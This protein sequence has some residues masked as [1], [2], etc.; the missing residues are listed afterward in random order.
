PDGRRA[1]APRC[2]RGPQYRTRVRRHEP[3]SHRGTRYLCHRALAPRRRCRHHRPLHPRDVEVRTAHR[4]H[5]G[6]ETRSRSVDCGGDVMSEHELAVPIEPFEWFT[7]KSVFDGIKRGGI[8]EFGL[9]PASCRN[10]YC[11]VPARQIYTVVDDGLRQP[12]HGLVWLNPPF[13]GRRGHVPWLQ[14]FFAHGNGIALCA[15]R[16]SADWFHQVVVP[17]AELICFP[18]GKIKFV[19]PNGSIGKEPG[20]GVCLIGAGSVA[21][22][23][24]LRSGLGACVRIIRSESAH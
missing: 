10:P 5:H 12:W 3:A 16:T 1:Q 6:A 13:G 7:P 18:N 9:D 21:C 22:E 24:L 19:K 15:A 23:A 8:E 14:K 20:T 11:C 2:G 4:R 17:N